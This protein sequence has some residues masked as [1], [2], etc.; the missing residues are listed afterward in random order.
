MAEP[1]IHEGETDDEEMTAT[2]LPA[3]PNSRM[4]LG[5]IFLTLGVLWAMLIYQ[6]SSDWRIIPEYA[7]GW[8]VPFL[9]AF[10]FYKRWITRPEPEPADVPVLISAAALTTLMCYLPLRLLQE[11][12]ADWRLVTW[13]LAIEVVSVTI[14]TVYY[15]GGWPWFKHFWYCIAFFLVAVPWG[16]GAEAALTKY[17]MPLLAQCTV[18]ALVWF[19]IPSIRQGN[20]IEIASGIVGIDEAC[21][22]LRSIQA[23][24]MASLFLGDL[25][26]FR[27]SRRVFLL[28]AGAT[29]AFVFN[30]IRAFLLSYIA[31]KEGIAATVRFHDPAGFT[32]LYV[33]FGILWA[34]AWL[35]RGRIDLKK[36]SPPIERARLVPT[37]LLIGLAAWVA[38]A[39]VGTQ[40]WYSIHEKNLIPT[41]RWN[42][43]WPERPGQ[44]ELPIAE[45]S[46]Q[47]LGFDQ[48]R[49]VEWSQPDNTKWA[50]FFLRWEKGNPT[51][52]GVKY[53]KP[54]ICMPAAGRTLKADLGTQMV[55]VQGHKIP[56]RW[57]LFNEYG[58]PLYAFYCLSEDFTWPNAQPFSMENNS[59]WSLVRRAMEGKRGYFAQQVLQV[60]IAGIDDGELAKK[61]FEELLQQIVK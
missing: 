59:R 11:A 4:A 5:L 14:F 52:K 1:V 29:L 8:S 6:V 45:S 19:N 40:A 21:S 16:R 10:L 53:H 27:R 47:I 46:R 55:E 50:I 13:G 23:T 44:H 30:G 33:C 57:F 7:Y 3:P 38:L 17:L 35:M 2:A 41:P 34:L 15:A 42:V 9:G 58:R 39:E 22:G 24:L 56:M 31:A 36:K 26:R 61:S 25:Y 51:I 48:G 28:L 54:D 49:G 43:A 32:I 60:F 20:L 12:N 37:R 18:E